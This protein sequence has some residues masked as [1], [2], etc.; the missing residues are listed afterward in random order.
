MA[1]TQSQRAIIEQRLRL[2]HRMTARSS[3]R[4]AHAIQQALAQIERE[5]RSA[6]RAPRSA[7]IAAVR[8]HAAQQQQQQQ[9]RP[10]IVTRWLPAPVYTSSAPPFQSSAPP[11]QSSTPAYAP[12]GPG[13]ETAP[14]GSGEASFQ[15]A[16]DAQISA[17]G[18][19]EAS[20]PALLVFGGLL[21]GAVVI[22]ALVLKKKK[23]GDR[24]AA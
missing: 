3:P 9:A 21:V 7:P 12:S 23:H 6:I 17:S 18:T 13:G 1:P 5:K 16:A 19:A 11:F 15:P 8:R 14:G 24:A 20:S 10:V 22:A 2:A 4:L